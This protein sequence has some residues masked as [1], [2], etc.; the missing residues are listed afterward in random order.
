MS[1]FD[2]VKQKVL[3][4]QHL[5][6]TF[7]LQGGGKRL[8]YDNCPFCN[9]KECADIV[10][11]YNNE[12]FDCKQCGVKGTIID[13][14][15]HE[16]NINPETNEGKSQIVNELCKA[17]GIDNNTNN[18]EAKQKASTELLQAQKNEIKAIKQH[19]D[20]IKK[21]DLQISN[22]LVIILLLLITRFKF[23]TMSCVST[24]RY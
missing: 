2:E 3:L 15:G 20:K 1:K 22:L 13:I 12:Y 8:R 5:Q 10:K 11:K 6:G 24:H 18:Q 4:S 21:Y 19:E 7:K 23:I 16:N 14:Y 9:G 17:Y